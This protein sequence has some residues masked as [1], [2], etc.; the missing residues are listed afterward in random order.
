MIN[1]L[2]SGQLALFLQLVFSADTISA[3]QPA[4]VPRA[5]A[6]SLSIQLTFND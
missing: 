1:S 2:S 5:L 6:K 4:L 3:I